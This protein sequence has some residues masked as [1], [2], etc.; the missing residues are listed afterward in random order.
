MSVFPELVFAV[1]HRIQLVKEAQARG[2]SAAECADFKSLVVDAFI[3]ASRASPA[4]AS[5]GGMLLDPELGETAIRKANMAGVRFGQPAELSGVL[6]LQVYS[7]D[8]LEQRAIRPGFV[9]CLVSGRPDMPVSDFENQN[10]TVERL[11]RRCERARI[12]LM[13]ELIVPVRAHEH[14]YHFEERIRPELT[15]EWIRRLH[16]RGIRPQGWK[17]EG[18]ES[19]E[20][21]RT[22]TAEFLGE[23]ELIILGKNAP[24]E[25]LAHWFRTGRSSPRC[26]GFAVG[27]SLFWEPFLRFL[28]GEPSDAVLWDLQQRYSRAIS[29]WESARP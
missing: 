13:L 10:D 11:A 3:A 17:L 2:K 1:D 7:P 28:Q 29:L 18:F 23:E 25:A 24:F 6:P 8:L 19:V 20:A 22:V 26:T 5:R 21:V 27:R 12:P 4:V 16:A 9:K 15:A 14:P